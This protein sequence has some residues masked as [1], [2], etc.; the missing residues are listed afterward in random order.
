VEDVWFG[1]GNN[2][3]YNVVQMSGCAFNRGTA[4][5]GYRRAALALPF[6]VERL[7]AFGDANDWMISLRDLFQIKSNVHFPQ[8]EDLLRLCEEEG[9]DFIVLRY[10]IKDLYCESDGEYYIYDCEQLRNLQSEVSFHG[11]NRPDGRPANHDNVPV[12]RE[13]KT[14]T[15]TL[16]GYGGDC[17]RGVALP[18]NTTVDSG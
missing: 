3:F 15:V 9:L 18:G 8:E 17:A 2:S 13:G 12:N 6:E 14:S 10:R 11:Q 1:T 16:R 7:R 5:E 4:V